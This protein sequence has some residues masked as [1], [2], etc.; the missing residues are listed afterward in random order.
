MLILLLL[1]IA[2]EG[3][4]SSGDGGVPSDTSPEHQSWMDEINRLH[5][6]MADLNEELASMK[7]EHQSVGFFSYLTDNIVDPTVGTR[8]TFR[9]VYVNTGG[10]YDATTGV[11][12]APVSGTY[13]LGFTAS[14]K[15]E[16]SPHGIHFVLMKNGSHEMHEFLDGHTQIWLHCISD[17]VVHL[18]EGDT[19]WMEII[20]VEGSN[21]VAGR[22]G[23]SDREDYYNTTFMGFLIHAD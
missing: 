23:N 19:V 20:S 22:D 12:T 14:V 10:A 16:T 15:P 13:G 6:E 2:C 3:Q 7:S 18:N 17:T 9:G 8:V 11:F 21:T 1:L 4:L 5:E